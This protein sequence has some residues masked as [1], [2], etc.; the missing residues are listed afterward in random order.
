MAAIQDIKALGFP[1]PH[2]GMSIHFPSL[3]KRVGGLCI[4]FNSGDFLL[5]R[6]IYYIIYKQ[7]LFYL[8]LMYIKHLS[9][10]AHRICPSNSSS[11]HVD[12]IWN[13][14]IIEHDIL[15]Q[16]QINVLRWSASSSFYYLS[17]LSYMA[18]VTY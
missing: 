8:R 15:W 1:T 13:Y 11:K 3:R 2:R 7:D 10:S 16:M 4:G 17:R 9:L 12:E 18:D 5:I 6:L 14:N